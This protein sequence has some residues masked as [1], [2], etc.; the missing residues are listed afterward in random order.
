MLPRHHAAFAVALVIVG[1]AP[2]S[3]APEPPRGQTWAYD[4]QGFRASGTTV[5]AGGGPGGSYAGA[6]HF[7]ESNGVKL[8]ESGKDPFAQAAPLAGMKFNTHL[9]AQ[10]SPLGPTGVPSPGASVVRP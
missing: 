2:P 5:V 10:G 7:R 4:H 8:E 1:C 9:G 6:F 3:W